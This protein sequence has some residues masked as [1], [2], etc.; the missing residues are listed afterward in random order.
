[1][2]YYEAKNGSVKIFLGDFLDVVSHWDEPTV[3]VSD[4]PYGVGGYKGDLKTPKGLMDV[5]KPFI[6][7]W[8]RRS[9]PRTTLWFWN[10]EVGWA[11]VHPLLTENG[12]E[13][14]NSHVWDKGIAHI[15]GNVNTKTLRKLPVVTEVCVQ[16]VRK[17]EFYA[18]GKKMSMQ[19]WL[20]YEWER[21]GLPIS[22]ANDACGVKNAASRKY[23]TTSD[24]WYYP[25]PHAFEMLSTF[26]NRYGEEKGRPYFSIDGKTALTRDE[27]ENMRATFKCPYG[28]TNVWH[29]PPLN[30]KER[31]KHR[32]KVTHP[33]Q[34]P[35]ELMKLIINS[36]SKKGDVVWEP[37]GGMA[38]AMVG[39]YELGRKGFASEIDEETF[40]AAVTR[41]KSVEYGQ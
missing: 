22:K 10:T 27:W 6:D 31:I 20:R 32:S 17:A 18:G 2:T 3:I 25:P 4:G 33:N 41:I 15:A 13:F 1:M 37:F 7:E 8:T 19:E 38:S 11:N 40:H 39:A 26:A 36:S 5:Y 29:H 28:V 35:L 12:W 30:G 16:Y 14:V 21:T 23:L 34:K 24:S 9:T